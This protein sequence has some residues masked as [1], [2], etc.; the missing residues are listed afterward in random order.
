M[1]RVVVYDVEQKKPTIASGHSDKVKETK[2][3]Q[4]SWALEKRKRAMKVIH[5]AGI[6]SDI[7]KSI[8]HLNLSDPNRDGL[9]IKEAVEKISTIVEEMKQEFKK[10]YWE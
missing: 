3:K 7:V 5:N 10:D 2:N 9:V 4:D 6:L 8:E 1:K